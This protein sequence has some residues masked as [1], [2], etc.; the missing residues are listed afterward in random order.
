MTELP[1]RDD[2]YL[3]ACESTVV[4]VHGDVLE[5]DRTVF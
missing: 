3:E 1:F 4:A 5:L 2:P